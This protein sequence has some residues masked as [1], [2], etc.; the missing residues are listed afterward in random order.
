MIKRNMKKIAPELFDD[1][2]RAV[3][4]D[5]FPWY[6]LDGSTSERHPVMVHGVKSRERETPD[7]PTYPNVDAM[8]TAFCQAINVKRGSILRAA[9]NMTIGAYDNLPTLPHV[10]HFED[11]GVMLVY[12]TEEGGDTVIFEEE[13]DEA[14]PTR[15]QAELTEKFRVIPM[16]GRCIMFDGKH[17]HCNEFPDESG[18]RR[19]VL[20]VSFEVGA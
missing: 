7:S 19:I 11:H 13:H 6:Y 8:L 20:V 14:R 16:V 1:M 17:Y 2:Y 4:S 15:E 5:R 18:K 10:D 9:F 3:V 12:F